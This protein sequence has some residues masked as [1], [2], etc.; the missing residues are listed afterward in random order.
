MPAA[1]RQPPH[2]TWIELSATIDFMLATLVGNGAA[3]SV[4][5]LPAIKV[6]SHPFRLLVKVCCCEGF[7]MPAHDDGATHSGAGV[8]KPPREETAGGVA[9][10][11]VRRYGDLAAV[12]LSVGTT[13]AIWHELCEWVKTPFAAPVISKSY[14]L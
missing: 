3:W 8:R 10:W 11:R 14:A 6:N 7:R 9:W 1:A 2:R 4:A 5:T 13:F 12:C